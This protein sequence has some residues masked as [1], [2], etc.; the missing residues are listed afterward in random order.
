MT[1]GWGDASGI[2]GNYEG[3]DSEIDSSESERDGRNS[4]AN[5]IDW[6]ARIEWNEQNEPNEQNERNEDKYQ[7]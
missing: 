1:D 6:N 2:E 5:F 3:E 7:G 4:G